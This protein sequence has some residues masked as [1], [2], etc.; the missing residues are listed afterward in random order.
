MKALARNTDPTTSHEAASK[1][2]ASGKADTHRKM[3][4][5]YIENHPGQ[6]FGEITK[7]ISMEAAAVNKRISELFQ[8]GLIRE[9]EIRQCTVRGNKTRTWFGTGFNESLF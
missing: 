9:G 7:G 1:V 2:E 4:Y 8:H 6:T 5:V 3:I